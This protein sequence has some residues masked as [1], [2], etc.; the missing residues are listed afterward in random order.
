VFAGVCDAFFFGACWGLNCV[1]IAENYEMKLEIR[2]QASTI[3][4]SQI[5]NH[6]VESKGEQYSTFYDLSRYFNIFSS[7]NC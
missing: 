6:L 4:I 2:L 1:E 5:N 7:L 3:I